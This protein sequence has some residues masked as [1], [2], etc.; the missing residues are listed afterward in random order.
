MDL[1]QVKGIVKKF[2][3]EIPETRDDDNLLVL[4]VWAFQE[5]KLRHKKTTF[6]GFSSLFLKGKFFSTESIRRSRQKWQEE[7]PELRG[8]KYNERNGILEPKVEQQ[9]NQWDEQ[10]V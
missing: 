8:K 7:C 2:L 1:S 3:T 4:K 6:I 9:I 5:P 10:K